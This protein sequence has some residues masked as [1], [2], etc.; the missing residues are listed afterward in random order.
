MS[1]PRRAPEA[2]GLR[3]LSLAYRLGQTVD[4]VMARD[5]LSLARTRVLEVLN[6]RGAIRQSV[7]AQALGQAP[8]SVTQSVEALESRG[9]VARTPDPD[10]GRCKLV[11]LTAQG[12]TA[13]LVGV[14]ARERALRAHFGTLEGRDLADL[15]RLLDHLQDGLLMAADD[16]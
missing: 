13:L 7:L 15:N 10:D 2:V 11:L 9:L 5:G 6:L 12:S 1:D 8:R 16:V 4:G 14:A 3:Y